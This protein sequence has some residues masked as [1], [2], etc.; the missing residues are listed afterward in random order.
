MTKIL[1][2]ND[3][4]AASG[5]ALEQLLQRVSAGLEL[6][7]LNVQLPVDGNVRSF[8]N[9]QE[10]QAY[11]LAEGLAELAAARARLDAAGLPYEQHVLVG[12]PATQICRFAD[13]HGVDEILMGTH[14][15][16]GLA[17]LVMGSVAEEVSQKAK[18]KVT[19]VK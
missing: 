16:T 7:I 2:P 14:G 9:E 4:S 11:H 18:A 3:G 1:L 17:H 6:H 15:R 5:R 13:E 8:V 12:H 10:V 19:L